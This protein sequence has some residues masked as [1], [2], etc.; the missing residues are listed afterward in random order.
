[1][2]LTVNHKT[3]RLPKGAVY[4]DLARL[5]QPDFPHRILL[6]CVG[7]KYRELSKPIP[8][9][10][11][12]SFIT[13]SDRDGARTYERSCL[14]LLCKAV[15]DEFGE[16]VTL[17]SKYSV[18]KGLYI[19]LLGCR[20]P[21]AALATHLQ[22]R[23]EEMV[24]ANVPFRKTSEHIDDARRFFREHGQPEKDLLLRFRRTSR[25]HLYHL[26]DYTDYYYGYMVPSA[27][28]LT[29]FRLIPYEEGLVLALPG[30]G[31]PEEVAP[32]VPSPKLFR[33]LHN[34]EKW[35][36]QQGVSNVGDINQKIAD[37][38][39]TELILAD[40][41]R[42][43]KEIADIAARIAERPSVRFVMIAG[44][45]SSG[46]TSF[47]NRLSVQ[48][49]AL[50][51]SPHPI[52][53]DDYYVNN[54]D[55]PRDENGELDFEALEAIDL[56]QFN[57]DMLALMAGE[58]V[59]MPT[60]NFKQ[61]RREYKGN[62]LQLKEGDILVIEGIHGLNEKLTYRIPSE[63]KFR[64]YIS[65]LLQTNID[66]HN[67]IPSTDGRLLRRMVRDARTRGNSA[68]DTLARWPSV[69]RGEE[70]NIFPFQEQADVIFNSS[71][72][73]ELS[74]LKS[75]AEQI[76]FGIPED[77][78][79]YPEAKRLLKFLDYF[80]GADSTLVPQ[81]SLLKEFIGGSIFK[82]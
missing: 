5:A 21:D 3:Y 30:S 14:M 82:V 68:Q 31:S 48:L 44:P 69:R 2:K 78:P 35:S 23:M 56:E 13:A 74:V 10:C 33:T 27:G 41:A 16:S 36:A 40:E 9:D 53:V 63:G 15:H 6:A 28:Y 26:E 25:V 80:L 22:S 34:A 38:E 73:Y 75:Y 77:A 66:C 46:K 43:E 81:N 65:A 62:Y 18:N 39:M 55:A 11:T 12:V 7:S 20:K 32:F 4:E 42:Q 1:M 76:L 37:G 70:R 57:N 24:R 71:L 51:L 50:G 49:R 17:R 67:R 45:S 59:E 72:V 61:G 54:C 52:A 64:I 79:E 47:S 60:F 8:G 58:R 19:E 29:A